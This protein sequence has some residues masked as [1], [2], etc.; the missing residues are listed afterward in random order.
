MGKRA[1]KSS[2]ARFGLLLAVFAVFLAV[3][4]EVNRTY[5]LIQS[6]RAFWPHLVDN[7]DY[8]VQAFNYLPANK[9]GEIGWFRRLLGDFSCGT[10]LYHPNQDPDG[11][12]LAYIRNLFPEA[13][14]CGWSGS[15]EPMPAGIVRL[16][17]EISV[18]DFL[19]GP[20]DPRASI[21]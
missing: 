5:S 20:E 9:P 4:G 11:K 21:R 2:L 13:I 8:S 19:V 6:R 14:I 12:E 15:K 10:L 1:Q 18:G 7:C 16:G 3:A 17:D